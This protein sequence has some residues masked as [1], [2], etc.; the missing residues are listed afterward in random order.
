MASVT[1]SGAGPPLPVL[2]LMPKS[3]SGPPGLWLAERISP[4]QVPCLRITQDAAGVD[5]MPPCP[6]STLPMPLAAA[7]LQ[8][9]LDRLAVVVAPVA[10][11]HQRAAG[12]R[13]DGVE[14]RLDEVLQISRRL[15]H[16]DLLAQA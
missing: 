16:G 8:D 11:Q 12:G 2:Y 10:A 5:R 9:D 7:M 3:P 6:T 13:G 14:H 1:F 4:P 15:E